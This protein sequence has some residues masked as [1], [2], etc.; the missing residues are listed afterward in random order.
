MWTGNNQLGYASPA[1]DLAKQLKAWRGV[2]GRGR[3]ARGEMSQT[4]AAKRLG[5]PLR[6]YQK[7]EQGE[8]QPADFALKFV[9]QKTG[10]PSAS[11]MKPKAKGTR[12]ARRTGKRR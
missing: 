4:E 11:N 5:V 6:T 8:T 3:K 9:L 2:T 7:W 10:R 12:P 1:M